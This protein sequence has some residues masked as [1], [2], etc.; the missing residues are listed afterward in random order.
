MASII[1]NPDQ[2]PGAASTGYG[3]QNEQIYAMRVGHIMLGLT[4]M[5][6]TTLPKIADGSVVEV[7]GAFYGCKNGD[8]TIGGSAVAS[9]KNYIYAVPNGDAA[10][11]TFLSGGTTPTEPSW[12]AKKG[13]WYNGNNRAVARIFYL[14]G[15]YYDKIVLDNYAAGASSSSNAPIPDPTGNPTWW[16]GNGAPSTFNQLPDNYVVNALPGGYHVVLRGALGGAGGTGG[17]GYNGAAP[18]GS[19]NPIPATA[20]GLTELVAKFELTEDTALHIEIGSDGMP[21]EVGADGGPWYGTNDSHSGGG[22]GGGGG[23]GS[24]GGRTALYGPTTVIAHAG[25]GGVGQNGTDALD[26]AVALNRGVGGKG[27]RQRIY[28]AAEADGERGEDGTAGADYNPTAATFYSG[29]E[30]GRGGRGG[31]YNV[32]ANPAPTNTSAFVKIWKVW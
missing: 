7:N 1:T 25:R 23:A 5:A 2:V 30:G 32:T 20:T 18:S 27:G 6:D 28:I 16:F 19:T 3:R 24:D 4:G 31:L 22:G 11:F 10:S 12:N 13:G 8:E 17:T 26:A 9:K 21:G 15:Q 29:G 14:N